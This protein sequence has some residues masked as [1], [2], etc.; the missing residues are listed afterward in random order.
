MQGNLLVYIFTTMHLTLLLDYK[1]AFTFRFCCT[2][3][4]NFRFTTFKKHKIFSTIYQ[5]TRNSW[6]KISVLM[7]SQ[8]SIIKGCYKNCIRLPNCILPYRNEFHRIVL[9][10]LRRLANGTIQLHFWTYEHTLGQSSRVHMERLCLADSGLRYV[11]Q[12]SI[13]HSIKDKNVFGETFSIIPR[14]I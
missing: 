8:K 6:L 13:H 5:K 12:K 4:K 1:N 11:S 9:R 3:D 10:T 7:A 14:N 2:M